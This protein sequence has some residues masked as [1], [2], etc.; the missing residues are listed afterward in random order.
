M[1]Q[2]CYILTTLSIALLFIQSCSIREKETEVVGYD[3]LAVK[4]VLETMRNRRTV[5]EFRPNSIPNERID[6]IIDAARF[7]PTAGNIQPWKFVVI[8]TRGRL[9]SLTVILK[10]SWSKKIESHTEL[11]PAD[12][13]TYISQGRAYLDKVMKAPVYI[14]VFADTAASPKYALFD[15]CL[16]MENLMLAARALGYGTGFFTTY[17][18]EEVMKEFVKAPDELKFL[19]ATPVGIP[20]E[21]PDTPPKKNLN[22]I[23]TRDKFTK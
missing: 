22:D 23:L 9:D 14:L 13:E 19:C 1:P 6:A 5:R 21:W 2:V 11:T 12:R 10:E 7:A 17:F 3:S 4:A 8:D 15:A 20:K 16:A 18:P